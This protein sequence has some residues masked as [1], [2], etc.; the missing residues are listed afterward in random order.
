MENSIFLKGAQINQIVEF[1]TSGFDIFNPGIKYNIYFHRTEKNDFAKLRIRASTE[2]LKLGER[3]IKI[4]G[5]G[6]AFQ[7]FCIKKEEGVYL[8]IEPTYYI[9]RPLLLGLFFL[10][11]FTVGYVAWIFIFSENVYHQKISESTLDLMFKIFY[12]L[13]A[14]LIPLLYL[15]IIYHAWIKLPKNSRK[16]VDLYLIDAISSRFDN[17][18]SFNLKNYQ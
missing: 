9:L 14:I 6:F 13:P 11:L 8:R 18:T 17:M 2:N 1:A 10:T 12:V 4:L 3:H 16:F 7:L 5:K 15:F